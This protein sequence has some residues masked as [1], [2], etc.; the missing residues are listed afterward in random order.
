MQHITCEINGRVYDLKVVET[1]E[2][3]EIGLVGV[4]HLEED[5][6]IMF[7]FEKQDE[8]VFTM[9]GMTIPID[10][11]FVNQ[12]F[13]VTDVWRAKPGDKDFSAVAYTV[14]ELPINSDV[15]IGDF[16]FIDDGKTTSQMYVLNEKGDIQ[17]ALEGGERIFS[18]KSTKEMIRLAKRAKQN[19][20]NKLKYRHFC[21]KLGKYIFKELDA[22]DN[23]KIET[24]EIPE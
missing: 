11:V 22:Q 24:V 8:V 12:E 17:M 21:I 14:I 9:E 7:P 13:Q 6:G 23:R 18:R 1:Q 4:D 15:N 3:A 5:E 20:K 19:R 16:V 2:E 10:V